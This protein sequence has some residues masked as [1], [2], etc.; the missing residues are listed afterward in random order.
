MEYATLFTSLIALVMSLGSVYVLQARKKFVIAIGEIAGILKELSVL[1][2]MISEA[3]ADDK[4]TQEELD[5]IVMQAKELQKGV[6]AFK[7][8]LDW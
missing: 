4:I 2:I 1:L 8:W 7:S 6:A 3:Q 5:R